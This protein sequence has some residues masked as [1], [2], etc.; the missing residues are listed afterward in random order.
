MNTLEKRVKML[1]S[2]PTWARSF[3]IGMFIPYTRTSN[4]RFEKVTASEIIVSIKN[5]RSIRNHIGQIHACA[6][7]LI[8]ESATGILTGLNCAD[9][10]MP[11]IKNLNTSFVRRSKGWMRATATLSQ[12]QRDFIKS[13]SKGEITVPVKIVDSTGEEPIIVEAVW[14]WTKKR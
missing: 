7:I 10:C 12:E 2:L 9:D 8:A 6:M 1:E 3:A 4:L 5:K 14:A 11:L 13:T